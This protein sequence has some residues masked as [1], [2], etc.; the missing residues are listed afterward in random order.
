MRFRTAGSARSWHRRASFAIDPR[1]VYER[2]INRAALRSGGLPSLA[3]RLDIP[4]AKLDEWLEGR[5]SPDE[6]TVLRMLEIALD[7]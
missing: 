1:N 5:D 7:G 6:A 2:L 3:R 4:Q